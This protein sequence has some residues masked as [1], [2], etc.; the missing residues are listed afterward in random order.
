MA[1]P[2]PVVVVRE[3]RGLGCFGIGCIVVLIV[4]LVLGG[5][6]GTVGYLLY[7]KFNGMMTTHPSTIQTYDGGDAMYQAASK[8]VDDFNQAVA[9]HKPATL[10]LNA[11]EINTLIARSQDFKKNNVQAF[12]TINGDVAELKASIP[13]DL[14]PTTAAFKGRYLDADF[15]FGLNLDQSSKT[16]HM[17]LKKI[18]IGSEEIPAD[19]LSMMQEQLDPTLNQMLQSDPNCQSVIDRAKTIEVKNGELVIELE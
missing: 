16:V 3:K 18:R 13:L 15:S 10:H 7:S 17:L 11:N 9:Q 1:N 5:L 6:V 19:Y 2:P 8:K 14:I 12:V 4:L